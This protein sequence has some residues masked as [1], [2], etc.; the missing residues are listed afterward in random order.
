VPG[1]V[2]APV[3]NAAASLP[4]AAP[5]QPVAP[6]RE[7]AHDIL[8]ADRRQLNSLFS[9][10]LASNGSATK[11]FANGLATTLPANRFS[12]GSPSR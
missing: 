3:K 1:I 8:R 10:A 12:K 7:P 5:T 6:K 11:G 2:G 9:A 4:A